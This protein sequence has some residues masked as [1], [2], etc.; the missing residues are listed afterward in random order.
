MQL[1]K[2]KTGRPIYIVLLVLVSV[3]VI[4]LFVL[5]GLFHIR[6]VDVIGNEYYS[7]E[8]I[9]KMVMSDSLSENSLYLTWK[10][11]QP[12]AAADLTFLSAVVVTMVNPYQVRLKY[13]RKAL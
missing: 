11:S 3:I 1:Q 13:M 5:F 2:K 9:Q 4:A 10:Y 6:Q 12:D 7:A 8:E